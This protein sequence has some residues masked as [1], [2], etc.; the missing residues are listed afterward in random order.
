MPAV[1]LDARL[2]MRRQSG[3]EQDLID[4][5][6]GFNEGPRAADPSGD[7]GIVINTSFAQWS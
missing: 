4:N 6:F 2:T 7:V 5:D 1:V 3:S